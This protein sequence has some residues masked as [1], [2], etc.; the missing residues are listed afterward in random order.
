MNLAPGVVNNLLRHRK[1]ETGPCV[2]V[3]FLNDA[4]DL[5]EASLLLL[6]YATATVRDRKMETGLAPAHPQCNEALPSV[7][8]AVVKQIREDLSQTVVVTVYRDAV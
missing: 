7:L 3:P 4:K 1:P 6:R 8:E 5:K 2:L